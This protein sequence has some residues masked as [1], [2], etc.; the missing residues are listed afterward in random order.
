[1]RTIFVVVTDVLVHQ[2]LQMEFIQDDHMVEQISSTVAYPAFSNTVLPRT[3]KAG[4]LWLNAQHLNRLDHLSVEVG[5]A[6]K[7]QILREES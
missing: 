4:P 7:D 1:M 2:A 6:I 5:G 3:P